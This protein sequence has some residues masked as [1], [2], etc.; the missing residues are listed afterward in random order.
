MR[1]SQ[2]FAFHNVA[3]HGGFSRAAEAML[4]SQPAVSEQIRKLEQAHDVLLF[5]RERKTVRLS[6]DGE[7]LF[8]LTKQLFEVEDQIKD[9]M[10]ETRSAADGVLRIIV[11]SAHH[12]TGILSEFRRSYPK[13]LVSLR[14]GNSE[15]VLNA[16]RNY[17]AEVGVV[18]SLNPGKDME[19]FDL[20]SSAIVAFAAKGFLSDDR[21]EISLP[22]LANMSL[23]FREKSSKTR[24]KLEAAADGLGV[25]LQPVIEAEGREAV[26]EIVASGAGVGFVSLTEFGNDDRVRK[27]GIAGCDLRMNETM[28]YLRQRRDLRVIRLFMEFAINHTSTQNSVIA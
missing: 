18:G 9:Y 21:R 22:D 27:L 6:K 14:T 12:I 20:G 7:G 24:Q 3:L 11:D 15:D 17:D 4:I 10:T 2:L 23:V 28:I 5:H 16:L 19:P 1:Q 26:R 25:K 8:L 13:I